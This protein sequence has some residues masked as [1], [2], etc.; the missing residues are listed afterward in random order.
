M[1]GRSIRIG[2]LAI[3]R[4]VRRLPAP[5]DVDRTDAEQRHDPAQLVDR[6]RI[7]EILPHRQLDARLAHDLQRS[8]AF[9]AARVVKEDVS[10]GQRISRRQHTRYASAA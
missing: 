7:A 8:A 2:C 3:E 4:S 6:Q 10:H 9:A 5:H 1:I